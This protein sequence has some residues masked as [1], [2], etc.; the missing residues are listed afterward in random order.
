[1]TTITSP[2]N[3]QRLAKRSRGPKPMRG[4]TVAKRCCGGPASCA[5]K[6]LSSRRTMARLTTPTAVLGGGID[7]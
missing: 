6:G 1:M 5:G 3:N 2:S 4:A 7:E